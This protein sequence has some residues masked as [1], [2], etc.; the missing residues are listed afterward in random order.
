MARR[1]NSNEKDCTH[2]WV[3]ELTLVSL[4]SV[5]MRGAAVG[6]IVLAVAACSSPPGDDMGEDVGEDEVLRTRLE[7]RD[8]MRGYYEGLAQCMPGLLHG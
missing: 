6:I 4:S 1:R 7:F 3:A 5:I 8:D 2:S